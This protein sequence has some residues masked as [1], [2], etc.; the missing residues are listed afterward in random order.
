MPLPKSLLPLLNSI[1]PLPNRPRQRLP[2]IRLVFLLICLFFFSF[3]R[4]WPSKCFFLYTSWCRLHYKAKKLKKI[5]KRRW[6]CLK[7][8]KKV[9]NTVE[10]RTKMEKEK[11]EGEK[12]QWKRKHPW[13][14]ERLVK[15]RPMQCTKKKKKERKKERNKSNSVRTTGAF[16]ANCPSTCLWIVF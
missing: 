13:C 7:H 5:S 2:C 14:V 1:L 12:K 10:E 16:S 9:E 15:R 6:N 4:F 8:R 3:F 11:N